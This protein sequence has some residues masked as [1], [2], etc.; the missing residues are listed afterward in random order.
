MYHI[1][2]TFDSFYNDITQQMLY[3]K[4]TGDE[5]MYIENNN[6]TINI[7]LFNRWH[8]IINSLSSSYYNE[9]ISL[10]TNI[11]RKEWFQK[12]LDLP[13]KNIMEIPISLL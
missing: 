9:Y 1:N 2:N 4:V 7:F 13:S 8:L 11:L 5:M 10:D 3:K 12:Y 6:I